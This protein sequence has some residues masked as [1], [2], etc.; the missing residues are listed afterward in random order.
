MI[1]NLF[2]IRDEKEYKLAEKIIEERKINDFVMLS[3]SGKEPYAVNTCVHLKKVMKWEEF[4]VKGLNL[5]LYWLVNYRYIETLAR[6]SM[7]RFCQNEI[8]KSPHFIFGLVWKLG[9]ELG[10][11][12]TLDKFFRDHRP[13]AIFFIPGKDFISP[14]IFSFMDIYKIK[15]EKLTMRGTR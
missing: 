4:Q 8:A 7:E 12:D 9:N 1:G 13:G 14:L 5:N 3:W 6:K 15:Y 2:L 10:Y 11:I